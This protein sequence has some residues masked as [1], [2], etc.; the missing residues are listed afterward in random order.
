MI[1]VW[2]NEWINIR[3][4]EPSNDFFCN[5]SFIIID[6]SVKGIENKRN[7]WDL[8]NVKKFKVEGGWKKW[9]KKN[10]KKWMKITD[11]LQLQGREKKVLK[12]CE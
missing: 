8:K 12:C 4:V 5:F 7:E 3:V 1:T 2:W 10:W 9:D 6:L 11:V